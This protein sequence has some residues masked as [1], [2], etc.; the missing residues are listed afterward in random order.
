MY[1]LVARRLVAFSLFLL[2]P[3]LASAQTSISG[4]VRDTSGHAPIGA[5]R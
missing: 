3:A 5:R 2:T 1:R 4:V